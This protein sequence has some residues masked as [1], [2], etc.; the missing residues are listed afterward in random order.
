[1]KMAK[2]YQLPGQ[3]KDDGWK[4]MQQYWFGLQKDKQSIAKKRAYM[5]HFLR[6]HC[7]PHVVD[8]SLSFEE[9]YVL[10]QQVMCD[11]MKRSEFLRTV[12]HRSGIQIK[13]PVG[14]DRE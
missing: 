13:L 8:T 2:N 1:M 14:E 4:I 11:G 6:K 12:R 7:Q 9:K 5:Q 10:W 3:K